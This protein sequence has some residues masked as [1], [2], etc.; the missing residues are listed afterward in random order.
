MCDFGVKWQPRM[1]HLRE[2]LSWI[3]ALQQRPSAR[4]RGTF[5]KRCFLPVQPHEDAQ[6]F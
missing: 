2:R 6:P 1:Y 4:L 5:E 3:L